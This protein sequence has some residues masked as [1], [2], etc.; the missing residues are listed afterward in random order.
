MAK[1]KSKVPLIK[2]WKNITVKE[3]SEMTKHPM[4]HVVEGL[5]YIPEGNKY[6]N[7]TDELTHKDA[8]E[9]LKILGYRGEIGPAPMSVVS[10]R[11]QEDKYRD[12]ERRPPAKPETLR[13]RRPVVTVMGHVDH[14]KTTL[15]DTLRK[16]RIV[17]QEFGGI[18][19]H[20]GAFS[21]PVQMCA[22][23]AITFLDTPG[24]AAFR[25]MRAR[26]ANVTDMVVLV[27]AAD[28]GVMEQTVESIRFA[29]HAE[30]PI[31]VAVNKMDKPS[32]NLERVKM[33][34]L[35]YGIQSDDS[36]G[37]VQFVSISALKGDG[38]DKLL[39]AIV[40]QAEILNIKASFEGFSEG[41]IL[42]SSTDQHRGKI[43][44]VLVNRGIMKKGSHIVAGTSWCKVRLIFDEWGK[45]VQEIEPGCA[46][47]ITGW[48][49]IPNAGD[50][51][52]EVENE[53]RA[54]EVVDVRHK[55]DRTA[56][57][58]EDSKVIEARAAEH[59]A[60][61]REV[62]EA[63][64][65]AGYRYAKIN[66]EVPKVEVENKPTL[67]IIIKGD[68]D[69]SVE[70]LLNVLDTYDKHNECQL[71]IVEHG[72]GP[73]SKSDVKLAQTFDGIVY[74]MHVGVLPEVSQYV[75]KDVKIKEYKVIYH[76]IDD[77]KREISSR[78]PLVDAEE[79]VGEA[80]VLAEFMVTP[81]KS[82][83]KVPVAGCRCTKGELRKPEYFKLIRDG[84]EIYR[85]PVASMKH[86]KD[87]VSI[88]RK[89]MECGIML[90]DSSIQPKPGDVIVCVRR[91]KQPQYSTWA[92]PGF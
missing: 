15:L 18:T 62:L 59:K 9:L 10:K 31:L 86:L 28:D 50:L 6:E 82:K 45:P 67:R 46:A 87:E 22:H 24:H 30:V 85:G 19:Q 37:D 4:N 81:E 51:V 13:P 92:P 90:E 20:I 48:K 72:V 65:A 79:L 41:F 3:I 25:A 17:D 64:W 8:I 73:V 38:I 52:L 66:R 69:G 47:Q 84:N 16:S 58:A 71:N 80:A 74:A 7:E 39:E 11:L 49:T 33:G 63:K 76:L 91:F 26:G 23:G 53:K 89:D 43:A 14:G 36:G 32:A 44:T 55:K 35:G 68:T 42:E 60:K 29:N 34:L 77:L 27:V 57:L 12:A 5:L 21:V 40:L 61:H 2:I 56:K 83:K 88:I 54:K 78:L 75:A 1:I 70:A